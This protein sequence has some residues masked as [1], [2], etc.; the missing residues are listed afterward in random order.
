MVILGA[1]G[2]GWIFIQ[3]DEDLTL[4]VR[5]VNADFSQGDG[6]I[7]MTVE[8]KCISTKPEAIHISMIDVQLFA[9]EN[10]PRITQIKDY[11]IT[12]PAGGEVLR[13]YDIVLENIDSID[14]HI[15]V[16]VEVRQNS[17]PALYFAED[18][19]LNE[20]SPF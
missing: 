2:A 17:G 20:Y 5:I 16:M 18:V 8:V 13:S 11:D 3:L 14:D 9:Y 6:T 12:I 1:I 4:G 19:D 7:P 15:Y 10:G